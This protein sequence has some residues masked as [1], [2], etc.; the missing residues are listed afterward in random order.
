MA[1]SQKLLNDGE[2]VVLSMRAH[3]KV[4][5]GPAVVLVLLVIAAGVIE[6]FVDVRL[7]SIIIWAGVV[8]AAV[9]WVLGPVV[10]WFSSVYAITDR[11]LITRR[12]IIT[13]KGHDMPLARMSDVA[14]EF[15]LID[16]MFGCGTLIISDAS[17]YGQIKLHDIPDVE[18][19]QR[20]LNDLIHDTHR[21]G[22][23]GV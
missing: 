3:P 22:G 13:R 2:S 16:R 9:W 10:E 15:G 14:Y 5:F 17:T 21:S 8:V 23:E 6:W 7:V 18:Q 4:L 19:T 12:G 11:R 20:R 1:I